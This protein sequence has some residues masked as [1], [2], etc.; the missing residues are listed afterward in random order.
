VDLHV[1]HCMGETRIRAAQG[2]KPR[3]RVGV[4]YSDMWGS[5][6]LIIGQRLLKKKNCAPGAG[7]ALFDHGLSPG[8]KLCLCWGLGRVKRVMHLDPFERAEIR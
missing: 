7:W 6:S 5:K 3:V 2:K 4:G 1:A 8:V